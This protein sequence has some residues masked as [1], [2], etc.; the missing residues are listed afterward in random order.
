[1]DNVPA[2]PP[3]W[4]E[5]SAQPAAAPA[6][7]SDLTP[8]V[9]ATVAD[10]QA[11]FREALETRVALFIQNTY[12]AEVLDD[13]LKVREADDLAEMLIFEARQGLNMQ[14]I[15]QEQEAALVAEMEQQLP[16][17]TAALMGQ[18]KTEA[19]NV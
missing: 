14:Q 12:G 9:S 3:T 18:V 15:Y 7:T 10:A 2:T 16:G 19:E 13:Y 4:G 11:S 17:S 8:P 5:K 1:M 6:P